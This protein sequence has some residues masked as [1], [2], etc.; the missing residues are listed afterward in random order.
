VSRLSDKYL[1]YLRLNGVNARE[2]AVFKE[3]TRVKQY[4]EKLKN[5]ENHVGKRENLTLDKAAAAR[6][7]KAGLV[8]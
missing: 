7:V 1:A 8:S 4:F 2:H 3:L 6:I 5:A